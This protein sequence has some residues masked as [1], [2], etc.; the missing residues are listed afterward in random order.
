MKINAAG[1]AFHAGCVPVLFSQIFCGK[2]SGKDV[3]RH[4]FS[5]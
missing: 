4:I 2:K 5:G 3:R 1:A